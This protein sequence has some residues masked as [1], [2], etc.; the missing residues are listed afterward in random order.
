MPFTIFLLASSVKKALQPSQVF[1]RGP[2]HFG[3]L[4]ALQANLFFAP[5]PYPPVLLVEFLLVLLVE[6]LNDH[7]FF[8]RQRGNPAVD[9]LRGTPFL[10]VPYQVQYRD[11]TRRKLMAAPAVD[12]GDF[13]SHGFSSA[14]T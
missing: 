3:K 13:L 5:L 8:T 11:A 2:V 10:K 4:Q 14:R 7:D 12:N 6:P 9:L 1:L